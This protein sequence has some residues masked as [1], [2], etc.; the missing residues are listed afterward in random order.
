[1]ARIAR[2]QP[3]LM[4]TGRVSVSGYLL[5]RPTVPCDRV[6]RIRRRQRLSRTSETAVPG[7]LL[8]GHDVGAGRRRRRWAV[9]SGSGLSALTLWVA[10]VRLP[11]SPALSVS[12]SAEEVEPD[13][14]RAAAGRSARSRSGA[15]A[16]AM[17]STG[18]NSAEPRQERL[19]EAAEV[20]EPVGDLRVQHHQQGEQRRRA[21]ASDDAA[22]PDARSRASRSRRPRRRDRPV[23]ALGLRAAVVRAPSCTPAP[24]ACPHCLAV[25]I[26]GPDP[27]RWP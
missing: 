18:M 15:A 5:H 25:H 3:S 21:P 19:D 2:V 27:R 10:T 1:M 24:C 9:P 20:A 14:R 23:P 11:P 17:S 8:Q 22:P 6:V 4:S 16:R 12:R 26:A 7:Q 13:D